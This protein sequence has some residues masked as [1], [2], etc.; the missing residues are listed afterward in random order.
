MKNGILNFPDITTDRRSCI[1]APSNGS[2]PQTNTYKTTPRLCNNVVGPK[3]VLVLLKLLTCLGIKPECS[4][5]VRKH[6]EC[7][8]FC[9]FVCVFVGRNN[10]SQDNLAN[11][12]SW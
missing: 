12:E 10:F 2:A 8:F 5:E 6:W 7:F 3:H 4:W 9:L 11:W 1:V